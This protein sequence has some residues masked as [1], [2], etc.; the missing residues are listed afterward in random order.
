MHVGITLI[1]G[2]ANIGAAP[3]LH[4][5]GLD[6]FACLVIPMILLGVAF[7]FV[8]RHD[9]DNEADRSPAADSHVP[10]EHAPPTADAPEESTR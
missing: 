2:A 1:A 4:G 9:G 5:S 3:L 6:E 7:L 8:M 10:D